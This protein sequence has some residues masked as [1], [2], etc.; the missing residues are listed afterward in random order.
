M[1]IKRYIN[2]VSLIILTG[3][4]IGVALA[5]IFPGEAPLEINPKRIFTFS[6]DQPVWALYSGA[7]GNVITDKQWVTCRRKHNRYI[8]V[9]DE[10]PYDV[11]L[12]VRPALGFY[13]SHDASIL[14]KHCQMMSDFGIDGI[15]YQWFGTGNRTEEDDVDPQFIDQTLELLFNISSEFSLEIAV[16]ID[17]YSGRSSASISANLQYLLKKFSK[18]PK[19]T[20][21]DGKMAIFI[22]EPHNHDDIANLITHFANDI[23]FISAISDKK[24]VY[25]ALETGFGGVTTFH[26]GESYKWSSNV[27]NWHWLSQDCSDRGLLLVPAVGPGHCEATLD[28]WSRSEKKSRKNGRH[29][30][31]MWNAAVNCESVAVLVNSFNL[32]FEQSQIE[33]ANPKGSEAVSDDVWTTDGDSFSFLKMTKKYSEQLKNER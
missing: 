2:L 20:Q 11:N 13:S 7:Y 21:I 22:K 14:R 3:V 23:F 31:K 19:I 4:V 17:S 33:A 1:K 25:H 16:L 9:Y 5:F 30:E 6:T 24:H 27:S 12:P 10:P 26:A 15:V 8:E 29:Y 32:W 18:N 28:M